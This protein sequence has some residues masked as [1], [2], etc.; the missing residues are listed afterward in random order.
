MVLE[1]GGGRPEMLVDRGLAPDVELALLVLAVG[2]EAAAETA[3]GGHHLARNPID[4][5]RDALGVERAAR[6][7]PDEGHEGDQLGVV[8]EH[9]LEMWDQPARIDGVAREAPAEMVADAALG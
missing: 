1:E 5:L 4:R 9:L 8:V 6:L 3:F 2:V 7:L